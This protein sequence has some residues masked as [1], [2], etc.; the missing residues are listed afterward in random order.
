[1]CRRSTRSGGRPWRSVV[2]SAGAMPGDRH[3]LVHGPQGATRSRPACTSGRS[4]LVVVGTLVWG[5]RLGDFNTF[6]LFYG[7][8]RRVRGRRSPPSPSWSIWLRLR[9]TG[10]T[11]TRDRAGRRLRGPARVRVRSSGSVGCRLFGAGRPRPRP[12]DDPGRDREPPAGR[13]AGVRLPAS[14]GSRLLGRPAPGPRRPHRAARRADVLRVGDV[15]RDDRNAEFD[16]ASPARCSRGHRSE[17]STRPRRLEA[18]AGDVAAF[19]KA[20]GIDYIYVDKVHPNTLVPDAVPVAT[21]GRDPGAAY[22]MT[23]GS[24]WSPDADRGGSSRSRL[25][26]PSRRRRRLRSGCRSARGCCSELSASCSA[27]GSRGSSG[28]WRPMRRPARRSA[29]GWRPGS[30]VVAAWWAAVASGGRSSFTPVAVGFAIAIA[31]AAGPTTAASGRGACDAR[32]RR[33]RRSSRRRPRRPRRVDVGIWPS[34]SSAVPVFVVAVALL[35][36]S[37]LTLRAQRDGVQPVEFNDVAYY[38]ILGADLATT[39][40]ESLYSPSGFDGRRGSARPRPG[41]TGARPG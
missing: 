37:T 12:A 39:G 1:M 19:L 40:T 9:A 22:P 35:Y 32:L 18:V 34:P 24:R 20:N 27:S 4:L 7:G 23:I 25:S 5:A 31:L 21:D 10:R 8:A 17:R 13:Q 14:R 33:M 26:S 29:S 28:S 38:S 41:T 16:R 11:R 36:G 3:R 2:V 6:H 15:R 30:L